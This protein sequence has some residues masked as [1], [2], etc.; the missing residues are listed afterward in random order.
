MKKLLLAC[1]AVVFT[2]VAS[3]AQEAET[4][5]LGY[6]DGTYLA[7]FGAGYTEKETGLAIVIPAEEAVMRTGSQIKRV[8]IAIGDPCT[9][10][11]LKVFIGNDFTSNPVYVEE[12]EIAKIDG[13]N[14]FDLKVPYLIDGKE[15]V[16]GYTIVQGDEND[17]PLGVDGRMRHFSENSDYLL[18]DGQWVHMAELSEYLVFNASIE[19]VIEEGVLPGNNIA[20]NSV[21]APYFI[22]NGDAVEFYMSV[23]NGGTDDITSFEMSCSLGGEAV[24]KA[25]EIPALK[26]GETTTVTV[27]GLTYG[28]SEGVNIPFEVNVT[29]VN[30]EVDPYEFNNYAST[31]FWSA[32][33]GFGRTVVVEEHTGN[34]C[35][36]CPVG[37]VALEHMK[38]TYPD[39]FIGISVHGGAATE[40]MQTSSY[41]DY[42]DVPGYPMSQI[43]RYHNNVYPSPEYLEIYY[44]VEVA[45]PVPGKIKFTN[46]EFNADKTNVS[47]K[48]EAEFAIDMP[49]ANYRVAFVVLEN[50]VGPYR[51]QNYYSK[52]KGYTG[53]MGGWENKSDEPLTYYDDVARNIFNYY[54]LKNSL[55]TSLAKG[56]K[57]NYS[58]DVSLTGVDD[59][60]YV[61]LVALLIDYDTEEIINACKVAAKDFSG[62][63]RCRGR[64]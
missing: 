33:E 29:K 52:D 10:K 23:T 50:H 57:Y 6:C 16:L 32:A 25:I 28:G 48:V 58:Y 44:N 64:K 4:D 14:E 20:V 59:T 42:V 3:F 34:W 35:G 30:G 49:E 62:C 13:W 53:E 61:E 24:E 36:N 2:A 46:A 37:M 55:S 21:S 38:A 12:F 54:G 60:E 31:R 15:F 17:C 27:G 41:T 7:G 45:K 51:Q 56:E 40:P 22:K 9:S 39:S 43:N 63:R 5:T 11:T 19:A 1:A 18:N 26:S 47:A 8:R